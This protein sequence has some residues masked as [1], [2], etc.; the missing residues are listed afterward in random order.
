MTPTS[1][2]DRRSAIRQMSVEPRVRRPTSAADR[3]RRV[4]PRVVHGGADLRE[5]EGVVQASFNQASGIEYVT[6]QPFLTD[7]LRFAEAMRRA[8]H[9]VGD[10]IGASLR[11]PASAGRPG[12]AGTELPGP[13]R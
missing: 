3:R 11:G 8:G 7:P 12:R 5:V 9:V 13:S 4:L 2:G 1:T 10:P 6:Y